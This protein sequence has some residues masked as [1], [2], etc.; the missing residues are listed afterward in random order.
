MTSNPIEDVV[1]HLHEVGE[2]LLV[3][4][5]CIEGQQAALERAEAEVTR[6]RREIEQ[7]R[8]HLL[9]RVRKN[10]VDSEIEA[11]DVRCSRCKP[12]RR[13]GE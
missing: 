5:M 1:P 13:N 11:A 6:L 3:A 7:A 9:E 2:V 10:Y 12:T 8:N 4:A